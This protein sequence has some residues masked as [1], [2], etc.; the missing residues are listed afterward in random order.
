MGEV[1]RVDDQKC[2]FPC[3]GPEPGLPL[4]QLSPHCWSQP[5]SHPLPRA[6]LLCGWEW[7]QW[8]WAHIWGN[9][10]WQVHSYPGHASIL[11]LRSQGPQLWALLVLQEALV[12]LGG[13]GACPQ[14]SLDKTPGA[15]EQ[16]SSAFMSL[17]GQ[18]QTP[19]KK[20]VFGVVATAVC[21][22]LALGTFS[23]PSVKFHSA[24]DSLHGP[25]Q[26]S[27]IRL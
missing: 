13:Q 4:M 2:H 23:S 11:S 1:L 25:L 19:C 15:L 26:L 3:W 9:S 5:A 16:M 17:P 18:T 21:H 14:G 24:L 20:L 7:K 22:P 27:N 10:R 8:A 12:R 6:G